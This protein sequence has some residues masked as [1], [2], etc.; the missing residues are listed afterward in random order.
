SASS[1]A[2]LMFE[3]CSEDL[4]PASARAAE[5][6]VAQFL[7]AGFDDWFA[8]C[9]AR[10]PKAR[11]ADAAE[12]LAGMRA[13]GAA[14]GASS[15]APVPPPVTGT[16]AA[17]AGVPLG[18]LPPRRDAPTELSA[19]RRSRRTLVTG[20]GVLAVLGIGSG[21]AAVA[22]QSPRERSEGEGATT[23]V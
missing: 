21:I 13:V 8:R 15:T 5:M 6:S 1:P 16:V 11:Y 23:V 17:P 9:V 10:D 18:G 7:P 20:V 3:T 14:P 22:L 4:S 2:S 19:A 12:T